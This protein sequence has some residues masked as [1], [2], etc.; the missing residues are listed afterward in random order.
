[1]A[2]G[3][4][5][6]HMRISNRKALASGLTLRPLLTTARDTL[7]WRESDAVPEALRKQPR[8][9]LTSEQERAVL[10]AWKARA[11]AL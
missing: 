3:E 8:Y 11:A 10:A 7:R 6:G 2:E 5:L 1:M 4:D 9:V